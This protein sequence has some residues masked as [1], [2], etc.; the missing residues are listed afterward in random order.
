MVNGATR[1]TSC[2]HSVIWRVVLSRSQIQRGARDPRPA[3]W[4]Q[5]DLAPQDRGPILHTFCSFG[6][7][8]PVMALACGSLHTAV[9]FVPNGWHIGCWPIRVDYSHAVLFANRTDWRSQRLTGGKR[10]PFA[11]LTRADQGGTHPGLAGACQGCRRQMISTTKGGPDATF[12]LVSL[13][14]SPSHLLD[15]H[16]RTNEQPTRHRACIDES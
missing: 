12:P 1:S 7:L 2:C 3:G 9:T 14:H 16:M 4:A 13:L 5:R 11:L 6:L 15:V 8:W 10:V